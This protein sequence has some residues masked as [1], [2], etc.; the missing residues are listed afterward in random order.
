MK[1]VLVTGASGFVGR[2]L[3]PRLVEAGTQV[4]ALGLEAESL[5]VPAHGAPEWPAALTW[6]FGDIRNDDFLRSSV[7]EA[8]ADTVI[9]LAAISHVRTAAANPGVAWDVNVSA[10]ARLLHWLDENRRESG[11]DPLVLLAGSAEQY[12]WE[13]GRPGP[14]AEDARQLPR[15]VYAA[16][17]AAQEILAFQMY[18]STGLRCVVARSFNHSGPGQ[19]PR[20]LIP[21]LVSRVRALGKGRASGLPG[22]LAGSVSPAVSGALAVLPVGN[23]SPVRDYLHV[24][25][26]VDA[27]ILLCQRGAAG[28]AYN[29]ASGTGWSVREVL[30]RVLARAGVRAEPVE[31]PQLVRPVDVPVLVGDPRKLQAATGWQPSHSLDDIIDDLL[32]AETY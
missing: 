21:A 27:Y 6:R 8:A 24:S 22:G 29:V 12:G 16:T 14:L 25:D 17:K 19:M 30:D 10:T 4:L 1:R 2:W 23:L 13:E 5:A 31:D 15:T 18:R 9:H 20:F 11:V 32:N 3:L 28:E 26:V 7:A